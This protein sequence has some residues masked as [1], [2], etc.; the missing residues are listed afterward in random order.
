MSDIYDA[1]PA[2]GSGLNVDGQRLGGGVTPIVPVAWDKP[3]SE[4]RDPQLA[5]AIRQASLLAR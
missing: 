5:E 2:R 3:Y 1:A 4:G